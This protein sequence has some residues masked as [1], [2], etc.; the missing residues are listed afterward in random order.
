MNWQTLLTTKESSGRVMS[1]Y[2]NVPTIERYE[3]G[4][5]MA[6]EAS[7]RRRIFYYIG[8]GRGFV[9]SMFVWH[10]RSLTYLV[11]ESRRSPLY[12]Q[13]TSIPRKWCSG[14]RF[15]I[16]KHELSS[17]IRLL[18][19]CL[20]DPVMIISSIYIKTNIVY[21]GMNLRNK[22][23]SLLVEWKPNAW[24]VEFSFWN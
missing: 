10:K 13:L 17:D 4:S 6:D 3:V 14:P 20:D 1:I 18:T 11:W 22:E 16:A 23:V 21:E 19:S 8:V 24:R 12:R 9:D 15:F 2:W 5:S 7:F